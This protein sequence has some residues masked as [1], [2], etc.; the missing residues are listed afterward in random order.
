[1][2]EWIVCYLRCKA[3]YAASMTELGRSNRSSDS[4]MSVKLSRPYDNGAVIKLKNG[5]I[6]WSSPEKVPSVANAMTFVAFEMVQDQYRALLDYTFCGQ[7]IRNQW[8]LCWAEQ[9]HKNCNPVPICCR[10]LFDGWR[11][12]VELCFFVADQVI[13]DVCVAK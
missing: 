8:H 5:V 2:S 9:M 12:I 11:G 6:R 13:G 1:M 10:V 4:K 3:F 7:R